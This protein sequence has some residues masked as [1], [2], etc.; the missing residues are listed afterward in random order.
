MKFDQLI[1]DLDAL[2]S[3]DT[4]MDRLVMWACIFSAIACLGIVLTGG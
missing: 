1:D 3:N 2:A 4:F